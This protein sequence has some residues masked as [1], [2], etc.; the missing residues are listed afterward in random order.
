[1]SA[2]RS[3]DDLHSGSEVQP[4]DVE[5]AE[6]TEEVVV[7]NNDHDVSKYSK[8]ITMNNVVT[9]ASTITKHRTYLTN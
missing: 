6:Y 1:M 2:L 8:G 3:S 9:I 5:V 7:N 4:Q